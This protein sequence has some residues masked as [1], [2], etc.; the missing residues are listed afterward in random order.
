MCIWDQRKGSLYI[1]FHIVIL[2]LSL[3]NGHD[4]FQFWISMLY[5][6]IP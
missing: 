1:N 5:S 3:D 2:W 6:F 4:F